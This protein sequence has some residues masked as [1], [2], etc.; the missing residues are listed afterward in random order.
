MTVHPN[1]VVLDHHR[2]AVRQLRLTLGALLAHIDT[3][4]RRHGYRQKMQ[5]RQETPRDSA[6]WGDEP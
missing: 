6:C 5:G 1:S 2:S 4:A 3:M